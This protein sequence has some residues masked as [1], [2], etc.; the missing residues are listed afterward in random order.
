MPVNARL[1]FAAFLLL[2]VL[3]PGG[4][5]RIAPSRGGGQTDAPPER[6]PDAAAI[7]VPEG[8]RVRVGATGLTFPTA[9]VTDEQDRVY[10]VEAGYSYGETWTTP[11]VLRVEG[12]GRLTPVAAGSPDNAPWTGASVHD[13]GLLVSAGGNPGKILHVGFD[14]RIRILVD[15][16]PSLGDHFTARPIPAADGYIYFGQGTIT[17]SGV[18]GL[19]NYDYGWLKRHPKLHDIACRDIPLRDVNYRTPNPLSED[20]DDEAVTGPFLPFGQ[21]AVTGQTAAGRLP[22]SGSVM[23]FRYPDGPLELVAWGFRNP[24]GLAF[25][26]DG[27]LFITDNGYDVRGSRPIWGAGDYLWAVDV[28]RAPV[29]FGWPDFAGG[30]AVN[31]SAYSAPD[32]PPPKLL[33]AAPP[34]APPKPVVTFAVHS[35]SN[36]LDVS[37]GGPFGDPGAVFVAQFGDLAPAVGKVL[38]PVGFKVVRVTPAD[39]TIVDFM[40]NKGKQPAPASW[41]ETDGLERPVDVRFSRD[42]RRLYVVD[43]GIVQVEGKTP[44][45]HPGSGV[46]WIVEAAED[47]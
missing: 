13:G 31:S 45:P 19:D 29:W 27:T 39:G 35:S 17:N 25:A 37:P 11:R 46:L 20:P 28:R 6:A 44:I 1:L 7:V 14:R 42:G 9:V 2:G 24:F 8:L 41:L 15:G 34:A 18:V 47:P 12:D 36:G 38:S 5:Y 40:L 32:H 22:C 30:V 16:L 10:I 4:C 26:A 33:L 21:A 3:W 43:F 23:R